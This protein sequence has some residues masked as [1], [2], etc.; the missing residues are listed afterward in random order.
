M[1]NL[2]NRYNVLKAML[3]Q[4][5]GLFFKPVGLEKYIARKKGLYQAQLEFCRDIPTFSTVFFR[6]GQVS[7]FDTCS[8]TTDERSLHFL[9]QT[10]YMQNI[11][12]YFIIFTFSL[13][14]MH[15]NCFQK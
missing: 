7:P 2:I 11:F 13:N 14:S 10:A 15:P 5:A 12:T 8:I 3:M 9:K 1:N 6:K 4:Y